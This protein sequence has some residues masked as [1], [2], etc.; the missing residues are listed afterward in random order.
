MFRVFQEHPDVGVC[1]VDQSVKNS[2]PN[3]WNLAA[4]AIAGEPTPFIERFSETHPFLTIPSVFTRESVFQLWDQILNTLGPVVFDKSPQYLGNNDAIQLLIDYRAA[5]NDV[6]I[7]GVIRDPRD[8]ITSQYEL[9]KNHADNLTPSSA[10]EHWLSKYK[11]LEQIA[12]SEPPIPIFRY[13]DIAQVPRCYIPMIF[14]HCSVAHVAEAY[15]HIKPVSIGRYSASL[16][17]AI[18]RWR[19]T[20]LFEQHL[21]DYGYPVPQS[22]AIHRAGLTVRM[23][24]ENVWRLHESQQAARQKKKN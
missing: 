4:Q 21:R 19:F 13:E 22:N 16:S 18:R 12:G 2:E 20:P 15:A 7:F 10:E 17:P 8:S 6:R 23:F 3:F 14:S 24:K 11:H 5:G 1:H 9:W